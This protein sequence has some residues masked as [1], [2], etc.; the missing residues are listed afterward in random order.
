MKSMSK[1]SLLKLVLPIITLLS[2]TFVIAS[3]SAV[4]AD[5]GSNCVDTSL[6]GQYCDDGNGGGFYLILNIVL[7]VLTFGVGIAGV[8][9]IVI[10]GIQYASASD[11]DQQVA[12][13]KRRIFEIVIGLLVWSVMY[14]FLGFLLPNLAQSGS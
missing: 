5:G 9:G 2:F 6:F 12:K 10:S 1:K 4:F 7:T 11:N 14:A 3:S 13:A 8:A